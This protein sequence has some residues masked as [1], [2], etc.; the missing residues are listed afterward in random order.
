MENNCR[1]QYLV[2]IDVDNELNIYRFE[3]YKCKEQFLTM[4]P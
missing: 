2:T 3:T 4:K 1:P